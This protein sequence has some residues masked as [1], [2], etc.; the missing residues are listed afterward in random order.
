MPPSFDP[1]RERA[2]C[3]NLFVLNVIFRSCFQEIQATRF[4]AKIIRVVA[5]F[6]ALSLYAFNTKAE[7]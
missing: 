6:L 2:I 7:I 1:A 4:F 5:G 3:G